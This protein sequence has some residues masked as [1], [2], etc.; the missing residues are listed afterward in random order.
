MN[1]AIS[2][3]DSEVGTVNTWRVNL[4]R[5]LDWAKGGAQRA[6]KALFLGVTVA[7]FQEGISI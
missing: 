3:N 1:S 5:H 4:M 2:H 6:G 7:G